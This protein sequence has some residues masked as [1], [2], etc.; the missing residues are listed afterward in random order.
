MLLVHYYQYVSA[1]L[2]ADFPYALPIL[3]F[4][5]SFHGAMHVRT[6]VNR[7]LTLHWMS[8]LLLTVVC[9]NGG[10]I[11]TPTGMGQSTTILTDDFVISC[12]TLSF[13]MVQ[14]IP[15]VV[16]LGQSVPA[17]FLLT[18]LTQLYRT[19]YT[20]RY[21]AAAFQLFTKQK[22][23]SSS[24]HPQIYPIPIFGPLLY[25][26]FFGCMGGCL[27]RA[28]H[29]RLEREGLPRT[30]RNGF[31]SAAFYHFMVHDRSGPVGTL[32]RRTFLVKGLS[33][34][35]DEETEIIHFTTLV[36]STCMLLDG[37]LQ[38]HSFFPETVVTTTTTTTTTVAC[39]NG[40][41]MGQSQQLLHQQQHAI[42]HNSS[43]TDTKT[44]VGNVDVTSS[45]SATAAV[46]ISSCSCG[47]R[48]CND[49]T[50][51]IVG[52][53]RKRGNRRRTKVKET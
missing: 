31:L 30:I 19:K 23:S 14:Y 50:T 17:M 48:N 37:V 36:I 28:F 20:I 6:G 29:S 27:Q 11:V 35:H 42:V 7:N 34:L 4:A 32:L 25:G 2:T 1:F 5:Q 8:A 16:R 26:T 38:F 40:V 53:K 3:A 44:H 52:P 24:P 41:V 18:I 9:G 15:L 13:L 45:A 21:T 46:I 39:R 12:C 49:G 10:S 43:V 47:R 33:D 22:F 51:S